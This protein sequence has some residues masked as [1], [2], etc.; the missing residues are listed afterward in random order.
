V[1]QITFGGVILATDR[2]EAADATG[3][4][5]A[6]I[7]MFRRTTAGGSWFVRNSAN[8]VVTEFSANDSNSYSPA[9]TPFV[10]VSADYQPTGFAEGARFE[11]VAYYPTFHVKIWTITQF[12]GFPN[13]PFSSV[14]STNWIVPNDPTEVATRGQWGGTPVNLW[15][16]SRFNTANGYWTIQYTV[17][18]GATAFQFGLA[19]DKPLSGDYDG[20]GIA[21]AAVWRPNEGR[22]YVKINGPC[23][24]GMTHTGAPADVCWA[25]LGLFSDIPIEALADMSRNY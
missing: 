20:D 15:D 25:Q 19:G 10:T 12:S 22:F 17:L 7:M 23:P 21:D 5:R 2:A 4:S 9:E 13:G 8:Q 16:Y 24:S 18:G 3:D 1:Y 6:D 14:Q 11:N